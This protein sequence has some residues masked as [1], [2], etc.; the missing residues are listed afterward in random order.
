MHSGPA[1]QQPLHL[2]PTLL[3]SPG[4]LQDQL[5]RVLQQVRS[6][7]TSPACCRWQEARV[8]KGISP[9]IMLPH[10]DKFMEPG[11]P[12]SHIQAGSS[13]PLPSGSALL[14]CPGEV[15]RE[16]ALLNAAANEEQGP[17]SCSHDSIGANP[18]S[19]TSDRAKGRGGTLYF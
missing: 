3:C 5:S 16:S 7:D 10:R 11:F 17:L 2:G 8:R 14:C 1:Q 6:R 13:T 4:K 19:C 15:Q 9:S 12:C 18:P